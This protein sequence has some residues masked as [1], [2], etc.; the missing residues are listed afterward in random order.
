M[1]RAFRV[2]KVDWEL[3]VLLKEGLPKRYGGVVPLSEGR[4][5]TLG[6]LPA[7]KQMATAVHIG[8]WAGMHQAF[9]AVGAWMEQNGAHLTGP[10]REVYL[11]LVPPGE[12]EDFAVEV[13]LPVGVIGD[14]GLV[15]RKN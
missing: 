5:L 3:G 8:P 12:D 4:Q 6:S 1:S 2:E 7:V 13:Q 14:R 15:K 10:V 11:N 9:A